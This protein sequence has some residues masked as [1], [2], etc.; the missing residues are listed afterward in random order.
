M[1]AAGIPTLLMGTAGGNSHTSNE[2]A[3]ISDIV[4]LS[5]ILSKSAIAYLA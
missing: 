5:E 4:E 3:S 1:Q 2:W